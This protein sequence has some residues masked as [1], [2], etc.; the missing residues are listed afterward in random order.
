M[1]TA[2][3]DTL[4]DRDTSTRVAELR[5]RLHRLAMPSQDED[6]VNWMV[7]PSDW[8]RVRGELTS[9]G[10][11][12]VVEAALA[13]VDTPLVVERASPAPLLFASVAPD[14]AADDV[15]TLASVRS[16]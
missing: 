10:R 12:E 15:R 5:A 4:A 1:L 11:T 9:D 13:V 7:G 2:L 8:A 6:R 14:V 3:A 16:S